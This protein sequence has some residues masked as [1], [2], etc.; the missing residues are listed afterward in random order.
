MNAYGFKVLPIA[1]DGLPLPGGE[2]PDFTIDRGQ[3]KKLGVETTPALFLVKP[4]QNG[5]AIQLGQ[6]LLSGDE[7]IKRAIALSRQNGWLNNNDYNDTLK[8]KPMQ[9]DNQTIQGIN[10]RVMENPNELVKTIR[11]NLRKQF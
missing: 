1:L 8:V 10:E 3:A 11:D 6:G 9:V 5:G 2:F 7:I 4:G